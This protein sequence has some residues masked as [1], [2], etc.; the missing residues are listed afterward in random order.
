MLNNVAAYSYFLNFC[1]DISPHLSMLTL[2]CFSKA[3]GFITVHL[4]SGFHLFLSEI[5]SHCVALVGLE[6]PCRSSMPGTCADSRAFASESDVTGM[7]P[8]L[9]YLCF[10]LVCFTWHLKHKPP[11]MATSATLDRLGCAVFHVTLF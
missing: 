3:L 8:H 5:R 4:K 2:A 11:L 1:P 9:S 10:C 7:S 6:L